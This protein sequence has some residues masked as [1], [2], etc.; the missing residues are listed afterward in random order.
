MSETPLTCVA[1]GQAVLR[2]SLSTCPHCGSDLH[3]FHPATEAASHSNRPGR[4][5]RPA[6]SGGLLGSIA[7]RLR[8]LFR[9]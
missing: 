4:F 5:D 8:R 3:H 7:S 1:C 6:G 2:E 9:G